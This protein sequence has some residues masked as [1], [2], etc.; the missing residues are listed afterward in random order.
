[1]LNTSKLYHLLKVFDRFLFQLW[2]FRQL[3]QSWH[4]Q[5][6]KRLSETLIGSACNNVHVRKT[7]SSGARR[8][9]HGLHVSL[10]VKR[11]ICFGF[12]VL[13]LDLEV[14]CISLLIRRTC[15][16]S[17]KIWNLRNRKDHLFAICYKTFF[18]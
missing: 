16:N 8:L 6:R 12:K 5:I 13:L 17:S 10:P 4:K 1:M 2:S 3:T 15:L 18:W 9:A 7:Q 14:I 11:Q